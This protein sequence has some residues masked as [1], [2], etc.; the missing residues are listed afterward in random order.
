MTDYN[1]PPQNETGFEVA[2][3]GMAGR[4]PGAPDI[5]HFWENLKNGKET[6][7]F[8][9]H[10]ESFEAGVKPQILSNPN[11][12]NARGLLEDQE[13]F[14]SVFFNYTPIESEF[15]DPQVRIF[16]QCCWHAL[17]HAGYDP[18]T[19]SQLIGLYA[20]AS[21]AI[22]WEA[23]NLLS[24][25]ANT[26]MGYAAT[27]LRKDYL[28][29]RIS[30]KLG[31]KGPSF[32]LQTA[33]STSLVALHLA[34]Q[35]LINS[36][37]R[38]A[39]AGGVSLT[40][41][42]KTGYVYQEGMIGSKDGHCRAF[43]AKASGTIRGEGTGVVVL[44]MLNRARKDRDTIHAVIKGTAINNDGD[45]KVG[46]TA[47]SI[48]GQ[49]EV[50]WAALQMAEIEPE[51]ITY[52]ETHGTGT[53]LGDPVEI[54]ALK[55]VFKN[56]KKHSIA[57]GAVKT[58][59]G[60][61][62][63][64]AGAAGLIKTI[65]AMKHG[66]IPPTLHF[67]H[68]NPEIDFENSP[69][70]VNASLSPWEPSNLP[71]R[72]GISSFGIGGTNAHAI[73]EEPPKPQPSS[74][75]REHQ[76]LMISAQSQAALDRNTNNLAQFFK[77]NPLLN[78]A[79]ASYTLKVGRK[80]LRFRRT[81]VCSPSHS[82]FDVLTNPDV[83]PFTQNLEK[84][85]QPKIV[86][87]FPGQ[88]SQYIDMGIQ[89]YKEERILREE[90]DRCFQILSTLSP[91]DFKAILYPSFSNTP[92]YDINETKYTQPLLFVIEYALSKQL[93]H[94]GIQPYAMIGHS[95]GEYVAAH[96]S[97][98]FSLEDAL[99]LVLMRGKLMQEIPSGGML[100]VPLS[101]EE[102]Q[103]YL[104]PALSI[105]AVNTGSRCVVS[106]PH[107]DINQLQL[108]L[109][110]KEI[111]AR[112]LHTSHAFHSS[113]M[114]P[115]LDRFVDLVKTI[116][117]NT[118]KIPYISNVTG[119]WITP[120][121]AMSPIY[122]STHLRQTVQFAG[123]ASQLL[124]NQDALF[125]E[126]GP[127]KT[128][129]TFI[130]Q[131]EERKPRHVSVNLIRHPDDTQTDTYFL[132][133]KIGHLWAY[134]VTIDWKNFYENESRNRIPLPLY[135]F[136]TYP[137]PAVVNFGNLS[138]SYSQTPQPGQDAPDSEQLEQSGDTGASSLQSSTSLRPRPSL[139]T[140][141]TPPQDETEKAL[142]SLFQ[143]FFGVGPIGVLDN[144][145]EL[146]G[147]S[148]NSVQL[149]NLIRKSDLT[150]TF[151]DLLSLQNIREISR[152]LKLTPK[153]GQTL[154]MDSVIGKLSEKYGIPVLFRTYSLQNM[155]YRILIIISD[156]PKDNSITTVFEDIA[157][158]LPGEAFP[159]PHFIVFK[160]SSDI[161]PP[162]GAI[163]EKEF[164]G[165]L[166]LK[167]T[168]EDSDRENILMELKPNDSYT[169]KLKQGEKTLSYPVSPVQSVHLI[170]PYHGIAANFIYYSH[171]FAFP[172]N[173]DHIASMVNRLIGIHPLLRSVI[174]Q[175]NSGHSIEEY[176][177]I[178]PLSIPFIDIS[179][180]APSCKNEIATI[181]SRTLRQPIAVIDHVL[182]RLA[183][184][185]IDHCYYKLVW[186]FN[187]LIF[188]GTSVGIIE[189]QMRQLAQSNE[190][191]TETA[192][193]MDESQTLRTASIHYKDYVEFMKN[194]DYSEIRFEN[195]VNTN[196]YLEACSE[197]SAKFPIG[198]MKTE[199]FDLDI[200][201]IPEEYKNHYEEIMLLT[202]AALIRELIGIQHSPITFV[203]NGRVYKDAAFNN[204]I[205][206]F[207][208]EIPV[209]FS[210]QDSLSPRAMMDEYTQYK[211]FIRENN[212]NF[213]NYVTRG[214][215]GEKGRGIKLSPFIFNS[216]TGSYDLLMRIRS[217]E[218]QMQGTMPHVPIPFFYL[219]VLE[220]YYAGK[221][222]IRL[223]QNTPSPLQ[224]SFI[225]NYTELIRKLR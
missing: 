210:F 216:L 30:Y 31:L 143:Q 157:A 117:L 92:A 77:N 27:Y 151:Q 141:Y 7:S 96:L 34:C 91:V 214:Y 145:Y 58:N 44:K 65:M 100:S 72:A 176:M 125:I 146:G 105:A 175:N 66:L 215:M 59:I 179:M 137:Y 204:I 203:S 9:T 75:S 82:P 64:A 11:Y 8:F 164:N 45:R 127:G 221:V 2:V 149:A 119:T 101:P 103:D 180:Y 148:L 17:E 211:R 36:E 183:I 178:E 205:G 16:H 76:L 28:C 46:F 207:P 184:L 126:I 83:P 223:I 193:S 84:D 165:F 133:N 78:L 124:Q 150:V 86:F 190:L 209:L 41:Q 95:I 192:Q 18:S 225:N 171:D 1:Q 3:I 35:A 53:R 202:Y 55:K 135:S 42:G 81:A 111:A 154:D 189:N 10:E 206:E 172:V 40:H 158:L 153:Q 161:I 99:K 47:P 220:D 94:W 152:K 138:T 97:S 201:I 166:Q 219:G 104:T 167:E 73:I 90:M 33:C 120:A 139:G 144:F 213:Y 71:M 32:Y 51:T 98:V 173:K 222:G 200:S 122:W 85:Y 177:N 43:D 14:D 169:E 198:S 50:I 57:L 195:F 163:D 88:G 24:D 186:M 102:L 25:R 13:Y 129:S 115:I 134:G 52:I 26:L 159:Y 194:R 56:N 181:I 160:T 69:F 199:V 131:H 15:M 185:K 63:T 130:T 114:D 123:G 140:P 212:F 132:L 106:G 107:D 156:S 5:E 22:N 61:L 197:I 121:D 23:Y 68:P 142:V 70:Y 19:Y 39:L 196:V 110:E 182:F 29:T 188:D 89:L 218:A 108:R 37:C 109:K 116:P 217:E 12:V 38:I 128:L 21:T 187:H 62:D 48:T 168:V 113:M 208:D 60:H 170:P 93:M 174:V 118:P 67:E 4:F 191:S 49:A 87:M 6:I 162:S 224:E 54:N 80:A 155:E 147:D 79:D 74:S 136:D 20:G 112:A